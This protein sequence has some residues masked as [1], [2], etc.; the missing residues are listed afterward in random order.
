MLPGGRLQLRTAVAGDVLQVEIVDN[1]RGIA[2]KDLESIFDPF[3]TSKMSGAG[4]GLTI[5]RKIINDHHG[6]IRVE[7]QVGVGTRVIVALPLEP[8][9]GED[10]RKTGRKTEKSP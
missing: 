10:V 7:S 3:F 6:R 2:A 1:G 5:T 8:P 9:V 4:M